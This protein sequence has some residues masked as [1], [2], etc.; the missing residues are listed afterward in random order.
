[1]ASPSLPGEFVRSIS[2]DIPPSACG[3]TLVHEHLSADLSGPLCSEDYHFRN[4][5]AVIAELAQAVAGGVRTV[6]EVTTADMGRDVE[7]LATIAAASGA[8]IVAATGYYSHVTYDSSVAESSEDELAAKMVADISEGIDGTTM[9]AGVIGEIGYTQNGLTAE[10]RKVL[11]AVAQAHLATGAAIITHTPEGLHA[12]E[13]LELLIAAGVH[14]SR[15]MIGHLD[16][17]VDTG[18]IW[19]IASAGAW[20]GIDRIS[21]PNFPSDERRARLILQLCDRGH[22]GQVLLATDTGRASRLGGR[23]IAYDAVMRSFMPR[24]RSL[25][26]DQLT[27]DKLLVGNPARFLAFGLVT[28][29]EDRLAA[30]GEGV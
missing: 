15:I 14:P 2:G 1:M 20:I 6:V 8:N 30:K 19:R 22:A 28:P 16:T 12:D 3:V 10:E 17:A 7:A 11:Q 21:H 26:I 27:L 18:M 5:G 23:G 4:T 9:R 24:L 29:T 13:Q 25:G